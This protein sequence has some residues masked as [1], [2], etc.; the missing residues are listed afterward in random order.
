MRG[1]PVWAAIL[2]AGH[3]LQAQTPTPIPEVL[4]LLDSESGQPKEPGRELTIRGVVGARL[5][6]PDS[7]AVALVL[8]AG[9]PRR[10][11]VCR[12]GRHAGGSYAPQRGNSL[13]QV[14]RGTARRPVWN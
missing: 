7:R 9:E 6:L 8:Q 13:G 4:A 11:G 12:L 1:G 5:V 10:A 14:G 2:L 3:L